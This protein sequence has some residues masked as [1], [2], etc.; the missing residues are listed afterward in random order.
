MWCPDRRIPVLGT[1][2]NMPWIGSVSLEI[3]FISVLTFLNISVPGW[4]GWGSV[5]ADD[6]SF[7]WLKFREKDWLLGDG[8]RY[9]KA[10]LDLVISTLSSTHWAQTI[11]LISVIISEKLPNL[12]KKLW[13]CRCKHLWSWTGLSYCIVVSATIL[14]WDR[15]RKYDTGLATPWI[16]WMEKFLPKPAAIYIMYFQSKEK[17]G[18]WKASQRKMQKKRKSGKRNLLKTGKRPSAL[19]MIPFHSLLRQW[20]DLVLNHISFSALPVLG[21]CFVL[22]VILVYSATRPKTIPMDQEMWS[23]VIKDFLIMGGM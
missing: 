18:S 19:V 10:E 14:L 16:K 2:L 21:A 6:L 1:I 8:L 17:W 23:F 11:W 13:C 5:Q 4:D 22:L 20:R 12:T 7:P 3:Y 15:R 9:L